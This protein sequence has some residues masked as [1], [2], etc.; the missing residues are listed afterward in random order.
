MQR[1][2]R[3][4]EHLL[5]GRHVTA[6][7]LLVLGRLSGLSGGQHLPGPRPI[8]VHCNALA[9]E[10][11][12]QLIDLSDVVLGGHGRK[13]RGLGDRRIR[14]LLERRLHTDVPL[15]RDVVRG[16]EDGLHLLRHTREVNVTLLCDTGHELLRVPL[17]HPRASHESGVHIRHHRTRLVSHE[18]YCEDR[19]DPS[20]TSRQDGNGARR[21]HRREVTVP[22][23]THRTNT[24]SVRG[25]GTLIVRPPNGLLPRREGISDLG[26]DLGRLARFFVQEGHD[27]AAHLDPLGAIVRDPEPDEHVRPPHDA[28][29]DP[30]DGLSEIGNRLQRILVGVDNV[31]QEMRG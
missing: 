1:F 19:L 8:A 16:L 10:L 2:P 27:L 14:V 24:V 13:V 31:V 28:E 6:R 25:S 29:S 30:A 22:E 5:E 20:G 12:R 23:L 3:V 15:R 17:L 9:V 26:E 11:I 4:R 18:R 7:V 21:R